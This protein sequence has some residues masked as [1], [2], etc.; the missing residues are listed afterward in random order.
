MVRGDTRAWAA[1]SFTSRKSGG[2]SAGGGSPAAVGLQASPSP[3]P[4][5][6]PARTANVI[7]IPPGM[8]TAERVR[9]IAARLAKLGITARPTAVGPAS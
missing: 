7:D 4:V 5:P 1:P 9:W 8:T 2:P 3:G 6:A